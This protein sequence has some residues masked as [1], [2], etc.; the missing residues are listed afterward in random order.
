MI[1]FYTLLS[2]YLFSVRPLASQNETIASFQSD[3]QVELS[4][5][6]FSAAVRTEARRNVNNTITP[7]YSPGAPNDNTS[8]TQNG[9]R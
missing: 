3:R 6:I 4:E 5:V 1:T 9:I 7:K 8:N 2:P